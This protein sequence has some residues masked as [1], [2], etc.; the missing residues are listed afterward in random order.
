MARRRGRKGDYL[1]TDNYYGNTIY[2]SK[3][4]LDW[5]GARAKKP[6]LRNLQEI[7]SPLE[8]PAPVPYTIGSSYETSIPCDY[9]VAP[10]YVGLTN[11]PTNPNNMAFQVLDLNPGVGTATIGCTFKVF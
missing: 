7:A 3:A 6:L 1:Y 10:Q 9:E 4:K 5:W 11:V 2:A 8:D